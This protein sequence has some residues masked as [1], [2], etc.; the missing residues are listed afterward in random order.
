MEKLRAKTRKAPRVYPE[1]EAHDLTI[2]ALGPHDIRAKVEQELVAAGLK[3]VI[4]DDDAR[5]YTKDGDPARKEPVLLTNWQGVTG[6]GTRIVIRG[7]GQVQEMVQSC[8]GGIGNFSMNGED[9]PEKNVK[10]FTFIEKPSA[11]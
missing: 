2:A 1:M 4:Y 8:L 5:A 11:E 9:D 6:G 7:K 10:I 3:P